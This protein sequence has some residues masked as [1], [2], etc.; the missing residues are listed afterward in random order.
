MTTQTTEPSKL[1]RADVVSILVPVYNERGFLRRCVERIFKA[2]LPE[3]LEKEIIII[4]D[5]STDGTTEVVRSLAEEYPGTIKACYQETNQGKGAA[6]QAGIREMTGEYAI[7]QD[8]DLEYDPSD[9]EVLLKP[10]LEASADV[11]YGS[12]FSMRHMRRVFNYHHH[13][14]NKF[15]THLSNMTTGL[16]LTD[17]ETG[18]KAFRSDL[19]KTIPLRSRRFGIEPEITAKVAKR[20]A[21]VYE[22]PISY[23]GRSYA[24]GKKIDW[25]DGLAAI[26]TIIKYLLI[27][28]CYEE[29]YGKAILESLAH[30]RR[31]NRWMAKVIEPYLGYQILEIGS[32]IGNV[33]RYLPQKEGLIVT[34]VNPLYLEILSAT[35][36]DN[37]LVRVAKLDV[38]NRRDFEALGAGICDTVVCLNVLE[39]MEDDGAALS[40]MNYLLRPGGKLVL[41]VPQYKWLWGTYDKHAGHE[42]RYTR[43]EL[44]EKVSKAGFRVLALKG[45]NFPAMIGWWLNSCVLKRQF[46]GRWQLKAFDTLV[47]LFARIERYVPLPGVSLVCVAE[48]ATP[49][50]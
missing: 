11:V 47:P 28:D 34:D 44:A 22:V 35:F 6:I 45:F 24:E 18:Y 37:D 30:A 20:G 5:G 9:Y 25:R 13:L 10:M 12:R 48:K 49:G 33:T 42:R 21:V 1:F 31:F 46:M 2:T 27:D 7:F 16:D 50:E 17:M 19:L 38:A 40:N 43:E 15:L 39:H 14:G 4:D 41:L 36:R 29:Q 3:N 26:Y 32:G 23:R 8:A